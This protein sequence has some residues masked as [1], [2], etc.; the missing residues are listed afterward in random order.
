MGDMALCFYGNRAGQGET[1][2]S[3]LSSA[4]PARKFSFRS[5][6]IGCDAIYSVEVAAIGNRRVSPGVTRRLLLP[7]RRDQLEAAAADLLV[8]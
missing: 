6:K 8:D 2:R 5:I 4:V 3:C 7:A 1:T